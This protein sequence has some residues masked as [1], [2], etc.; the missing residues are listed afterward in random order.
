MRLRF[1]P[2]WMARPRKGHPFGD[3]TVQLARIER[4][5]VLGGL[6]TF[7][8]RRAR[9]SVSIIIYGRRVP[10]EGPIHGLLVDTVSDGV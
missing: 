2:L 6:S 1:V 4:P 8:R 9:V 10:S 7:G 3:H 5:S